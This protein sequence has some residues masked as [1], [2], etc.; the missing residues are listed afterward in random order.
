SFI[1][2]V[3][4]LDGKGTVSEYAGQVDAVPTLL[5]LLGIDA[6]DYVLFGTALFSEE[7][8]D[9]VPFR[10]DDYITE[11]YAMVKGIFYDNHTGEEIEPT[12]ELEALKEKVEH[13]LA[14]SDKVLQGD[15]LRFYSQQ[16][17]G[18]R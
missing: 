18:N 12:E 3:T 2:K 9:L 8:D 7:H 15:L 16:T 10:N 14:M 17:I 11:D 6:K 5:H 4:G 13:E 1:L